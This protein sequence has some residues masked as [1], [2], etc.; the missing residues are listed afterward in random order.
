MDASMPIG[1]GQFDYLRWLR[2]RRLF[3]LF[4][5]MQTYAEV[6]RGLGCECVD[7]KEVSTHH[8]SEAAVAARLLTKSHETQ[9]SVEGC[10]Q[11][12]ALCH[13]ETRGLVSY[14]T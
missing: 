14:K 10:H 13:G 5:R 6:G 1:R 2:A 12:F 7:V 11:L 3:D 4:E 8:P 9:H